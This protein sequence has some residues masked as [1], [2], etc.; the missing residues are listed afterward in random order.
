[1]PEQKVCSREGSVAQAFSKGKWYSNNLWQRKKYS[2]NLRYE[3]QALLKLFLILGST[4]DNERKIPVKE[5]FRVNITYFTVLK[6]TELPTFLKNKEYFLSYLN[7]QT[8]AAR[9]ISGP[10]K[11]KI[12]KG[13]L[14]VGGGRDVT[15]GRVIKGTCSGLPS[16]SPFSQWHIQTN[17]VYSS[18]E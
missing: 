2:N 15:S 5:R 3:T 10:G 6:C 12:G 13:C 16:S 7:W 14:V 1:M 18:W 9:V 4:Y 8:E 17:P 11:N